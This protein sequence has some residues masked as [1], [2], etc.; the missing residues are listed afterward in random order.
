MYPTEDGLTCK[1]LKVVYVLQNKQT[2]KQDLNRKHSSGKMKGYS[3]V[4]KDGWETSV[5][6]DDDQGHVQGKG[7]QSVAEWKRG[8]WES[9]GHR[10]DDQP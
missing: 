5:R 6:P 3:V 7:K 2:N 10:G 1:G 4:S 8:G 9:R